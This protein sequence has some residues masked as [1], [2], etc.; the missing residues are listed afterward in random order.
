MKCL[1]LVAFACLRAASA[2]ILPPPSPLPPS[3]PNLPEDT[4][5]AEFEDGARLTMGDFLKIYAVLSPAQKQ[6]ALQDRRQFLQQWALYR[7]LTRMAEQAKLQEQS[8]YKEAI[9]QY[10][11]QVLSE[12]K[13][14]EG[15]NQIVIEPGDIVKAYEAN[16]LKY[17]QVKV[18]AIYIAFSDD[19]A[20]SAGTK[21][22]LTESQA[23]A[24]AK[25]ILTEARAGGD[26]VKL[27]KENSDDETSRAKDGDFD[28]LRYTDNLPDSFREAV[29]ALKKGE[30]TEPLKQPNGFYLLRAEEVGVRPLSDVR[31]EIYNEL[32]NL[33]AKV[34]L[35]RLNMDTTVKILSPAFVAR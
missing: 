2:Q 26:F 9:E 33:K 7:K 18:K 13:I 35:D 32:H 21:K 11:M 1:V 16:K 25:A 22:P 15:I 34:W 31:D 29:F 12:A 17:T 20:G 3:M 23:L 24:R 30:I 19:A 5:I 6:V 4:V 27:V 28:T 14:A 8:P 10:R